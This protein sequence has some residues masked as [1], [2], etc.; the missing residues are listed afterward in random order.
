M[1]LDEMK[2]KLH[3]GYI[4][5]MGISWETPTPD[6]IEQAITGAME[7][8]G[9]TRDEVIAN[10]KCGESLRWCRSY[11]FE[12]DH[13]YGMIAVDKPSTVVEMVH[14]DCGH[15][16]ERVHAMSSGSGT[17]CFDCYTGM[18]D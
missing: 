15:T 3:N 17:V 10:L 18:D 9:M 1:K 11:N 12:Y 16:V 4:G 14:C 5:S 6:Q 8:E 7:I 13:S 2:L